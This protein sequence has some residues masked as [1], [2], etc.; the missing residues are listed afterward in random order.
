MKSRHYGS[1]GNVQQTSDL[2]IG[3]SLEVTHYNDLPVFDGQL[4]YSIPDLLGLLIAVG[5][6]NG[7]GL[8]SGGPVIVAELAAEVSSALP[9]AVETVVTQDGIVPG[10]KT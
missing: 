10:I 3:H 4:K 7:I 8:G 2:L 9:Q 5:Q 6:Q 1:H